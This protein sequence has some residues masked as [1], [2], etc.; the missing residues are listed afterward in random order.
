MKFDD[1]DLVLVC[2]LSG[3]GDIRRE[4]VVEQAQ[5]D[6]ELNWTC[7]SPR[8]VEISLFIKN[9][10]YLQQKLTSSGLKSSSDLP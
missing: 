6:E 2:L 10:K 5:D 8:I 9:K 7:T 3:K 4:E 1:K